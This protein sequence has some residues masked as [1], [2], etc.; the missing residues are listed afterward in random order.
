MTG[1]NVSIVS[2]VRDDS[3]G[4][5][6]PTDDESLTKPGREWLQTLRE[7]ERERENEGG[8]KKKGEKRRH[9]YTHR[10]A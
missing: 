9:L 7:E 5:R 4:W 10:N 6:D 1:D 3:V 8:R 2:I